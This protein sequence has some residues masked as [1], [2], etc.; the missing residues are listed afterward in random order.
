[1]YFP[2]VD[3]ISYSFEKKS[4]YCLGIM[5]LSTM[6]IYYEIYKRT[7]I[8]KLRLQICIVVHFFMPLSY[9][10]SASYFKPKVG[11]KNSLKCRNGYS[12][13]NT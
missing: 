2:K 8:I 4:G 9:S 7:V 3:E 12:I 13:A 6:E 5:L 10:D 1:M 11:N